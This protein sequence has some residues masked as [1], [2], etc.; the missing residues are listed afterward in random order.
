MSTLELLAGLGLPSA[1]T[2][3]VLVALVFRRAHAKISTWA[4]CFAV[5]LVGLYGVIQLAEA[6]RGSDVQVRVDPQDARAFNSPGCP[7]DLEISV[8]RRG[9]ILTKREIGKQSEAAYQSRP[10]T[11]DARKDALAVKYG[12]YRIG[13]LDHECLRKIGWQPAEEL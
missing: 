13:E 3:M 9:K 4:A 8:V 10:L 6:L 7:V 12:G 5:A 11:V 1:F 2:G